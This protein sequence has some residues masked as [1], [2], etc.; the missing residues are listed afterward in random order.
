MDRSCIFFLLDGCRRG[1]GHKGD[2]I[3]HA[4]NGLELSPH[5]SGHHVIKRVL[6][7][8]I[9]GRETWGEPFQRH[10]SPLYKVH[11]A[12]IACRLL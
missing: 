9:L 6:T 3:H 1:S 11:D 12:R 10:L 5:V 7:K 4:V 2:L 8:V